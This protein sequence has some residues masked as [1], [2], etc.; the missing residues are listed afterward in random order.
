MAGSIPAVLEPELDR[1]HAA[2]LKGPNFPVGVL[3]A[4]INAVL[5]EMA[6]VGLKFCRE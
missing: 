5:T 2:A 4:D 6:N 3:L 1:G